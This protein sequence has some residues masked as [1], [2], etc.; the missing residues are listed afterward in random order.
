MCPKATFHKSPTLILDTRCLSLIYHDKFSKNNF[1]TKVCTAAICKQK[2]SFSG[3]MSFGK[4]FTL[5][6]LHDWRSTPCEIPNARNGHKL[7]NM[8]LGTS[9]TRT[10]SCH[11]VGHAWDLQHADDRARL[12]HARIGNKAKGV[13]FGKTAGR[14]RRPVCVV[15]LES[16]W[17]YG[18]EEQRAGSVVD[19]ARAWF[20]LT[21]PPQRIASIEGLRFACRLQVE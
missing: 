13:R 9:C 7:R 19:A 5:D 18:E 16:A 11:V 21:W 2:A 12:A 6:L 1:N 8:G 3:I 10:T 15:E 17:I 4:T 14:L 20:H